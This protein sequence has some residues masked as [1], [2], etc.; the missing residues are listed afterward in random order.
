MALPHPFGLRFRNL[1]L[2]AGVAVVLISSIVYWLSR[3]V[4]AITMENVPNCPRCGLMHTSSAAAQISSDWLFR[5]FGCS[6]YKCDVC[7]N[8]YHRPDIAATQPVA[9]AKDSIS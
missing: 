6:P 3:I 5:L 4:K 1:A 9:V 2:L 8:R 7:R